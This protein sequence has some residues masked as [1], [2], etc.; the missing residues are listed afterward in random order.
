MIIFRLWYLLQGP[1]RMMFSKPVIAAVNGYAVAGGIELALMCDL[2]VM[3]ES[4][5]MGVFCRRFGKFIRLKHQKLVHNIQYIMLAPSVFHG[6]YRCLKSLKSTTTWTKFLSRALETIGNLWF[7][8]SVLEKYPWYWKLFFWLQGFLW[9]LARCIWPIKD[10]HSTW[11]HCDWLK[12]QWD[13]DPKN[14]FYHTVIF[15]CINWLIPLLKP[16]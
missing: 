3:E 15:S 9:E 8:A 4:A 2:R 14:Y 10:K 16:F 5:I 11:V 13:P 1:S 6:L 7:L 12:V